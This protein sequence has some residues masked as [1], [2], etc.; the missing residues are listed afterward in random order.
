MAKIN[1]ATVQRVLDAAEI[2]DVVG[3]FVSLKRKGANW[4]GL[5]PFHN[6]RSPSFYVSKAKNLCKCFACG[7][8]GS[9]VNFIMKH[10]QLNFSEAIRYLAQKY[11]IE[12]EE[13]EMTDEER[14][15]QSKRENMLAVNEFAMR[16]FE[17]YLH[18]SAEG[19]D[20]GGSYFR[21]RGINDVILKKFH[22]G[23]APEGKDSFSNA[24]LE[25]GYS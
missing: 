13:H 16:Y 22:L 3:D 5:C 14:R 23:F 18:D 2:L 1:S 12:I 17:N 4:V 10:E 24:A 15:A 11:N 6:D 8:G 20:I 19:R 25:R 7:E 9:P 21:Y